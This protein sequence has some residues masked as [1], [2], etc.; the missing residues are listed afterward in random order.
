MT[1]APGVYTGIS[2]PEYHAWTGASNS[3]L[4]RLRRSPAHLKSY[5]DQPPETT[6]ALMI[7]NA[8]HTSILEPD[9]FHMH[10]SVADRC[11]AI[12]KSDGLQCSNPGIMYRAEAGWLC[13]QHSKGLVSDESRII[14][15]PDDYAC[16]VSVRDAVLAHPSAGPLLSGEGANEL[17]VVWQDVETLVMCKGRFDRHS[18]Q[19]AGGA[20]VDIKTTKDAS[21]REFERAIFTLGYHR[22]GAFYLS[23]AAALGLDAEHF[24]IV[25]VEKEAPFAVAVYRLTESAL[26]A[27][28]QQ[29]QPLLRR[30][31]ECLER[32]EWPAYAPEVQDISLPAWGFDQVDSELLRNVA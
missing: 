6:Q 27:G 16:C 22:Q 30:Y 3:R 14:L 23:A 18:P 26:D 20:I 32:D 13:G 31:A 24:V 19:I 8:A 5:L 2:M 4:S 28:H 1:P 11:G 29:I 7:G 9:D 12:K 15:A 17:S 10:F 25:A 21:P